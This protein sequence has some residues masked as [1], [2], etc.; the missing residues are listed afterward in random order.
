MNEIT[1]IEQSQ[2]ITA[3]RTNVSHYSAISN[4]LVI[5]T[6]NDVEYASKILQDIAGAKKQMTALRTAFVK[7][8]NDHVKK[9]NDFFKTLT[10]PT[11]EADQI[12]RNKVLAYR[13]IQAE[14]E[15]KKQ[16][17]L[18]KKIAEHQATLEAKARESGVEAPVLVAPQFSQTPKTVG[19][20]TA[21]KTWTFRVIDETAIPREYLI[22]DPKT[23]REAVRRGARNIAGVEI[24]EEESLSVKA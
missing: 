10:E 12:I 8:L 16:E 6:D 21:K 17:E 9:I 19:G 14:V 18:N 11:E 20:T 23:I 4:D 22:V 13:K 1:N 5:T 7:P 2:E 24:Y 15:R 3:V